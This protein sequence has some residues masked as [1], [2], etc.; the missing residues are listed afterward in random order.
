MSGERLSGAKEERR[1][2]DGERKRGRKRL[3]GA[4]MEMDGGIREGEG[5]G[6]ELR[7]QVSGGEG[8]KRE[9]GIRGWNETKD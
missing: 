1:E 4:E 5:M 9:A 3:R 6:R 2:S 7:V 8:E